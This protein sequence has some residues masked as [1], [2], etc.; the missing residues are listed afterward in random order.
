M[1]ETD[2]YT[3]E[4]LSK[5]HFGTS[6]LVPCRE[7]LLFTEVENVVHNTL[8][9]IL[10]VSFIERL[11]LSRRVL[12]RGSTVVI[13]NV[14]KQLTRILYSILTC[15]LLCEGPIILLSVLLLLLLYISLTVS[16]KVN[17]SGYLENCIQ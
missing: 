4:P 16:T 11:S 10:E 8:L 12:S 17:R 5:G 3:V 14:Q 1:Y 15:I 13:F 2:K 6:H 7:V 9:E